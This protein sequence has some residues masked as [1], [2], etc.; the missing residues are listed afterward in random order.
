[1]KLLVSNNFKTIEKVKN[2]EQCDVALSLESALIR[3]K[4][5]KYESIIN[6]GFY[7][8][9]L[10]DNVIDIKDYFKNT[11]NKTQIKV[12]KQKVISV[13]SVKGGTGKT[14]FVKSLAESLQDNVKAL[15]IDLNFCDGGSDLSF[16]LDLPVLPHIGM[17]LK[18]RTKEGFIK[19]IVQYKTNIYVLQSPPKLSLIKDIKGSDIDD[20]IR[21]ARSEF[22]I[23]IFDLPN[24]FSEIIKIALDNSTKKIIVSTGL[25]SEAKRIKELG[26]DYIIVI[27]SNNRQWKVFFKDFKCVDFKSPEKIF[28]R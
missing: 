24:E 2:I 22:D 12:M 19:N 4:N 11:V 7:V 3:A 6:D 14:T 16:M 10:F 9:G 25:I 13:W 17:Y 18:E 26:D 1:M 5:K 21:F 15:I 8:S 27:N 20:I 23:I 28:E